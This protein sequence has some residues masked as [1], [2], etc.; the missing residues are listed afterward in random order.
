MTS[1]V[2]ICTFEKKDEANQFLANLGWGESNMGI[3]FSSTGQNPVTHLAGRCEVD[4]S[5]VTLMESPSP[6]II[7]DFRENVPSGGTH[8]REVMAENNLIRIEPEE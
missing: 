6:F 2:L 5:F 7:H 1:C 8:F 3:P 4:Q